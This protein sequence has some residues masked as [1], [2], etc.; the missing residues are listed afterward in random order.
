M[1][2]ASLVRQALVIWLLL[3]MSALA[4]E[5]S[6]PG[7]RTTTAEIRIEARPAAL[8]DGIRD[9]LA[10]KAPG[11]RPRTRHLRP[12]GSP[13]YTNRLILEDSPYL[14]Q[15]AHNP[16]DWYPWGPEAF[17]KARRER[18][19][20]FLSIGYST[21]HWCHVMEG[22]S[23]EDPMIA[24]LLNRHF[25]PIKVDRE[26]RPE[27]DETYM[28]AVMLI[29]G[30][31]G[32][33]LS[34][35][36]TP[37]GRPFH[38][39]TYYPPA[40]FL[41]LL[42]RITELWETQQ[43]ALMAR[44]ERIAES[45]DALARGRVR[46][47]R[48]GEETIR[49]AVAEALA[50]QDVLLGGFGD[51]PKFPNEPLL[52]LL[53]AAA[54]RHQDEAALA[55]LETTLDAMARGGIHD[56][57]GGGFHRYAID[58]EWQV[59][60]FEKM[61]YNQALLSRIYL[62]AWRLTGE[63]R[64]RRVVTRILDYVL[65]DM[66]SPEG[67]F[68]SATDADSEGREGAFFLWT[69]EQIHKVLDQKDAEL[70]IEVLGVSAGGNFEGGNILYLPAPL[71]AVAQTKGWSLARLAQ[72]LDAILER[73]DQARKARP[74]PLR[75]EKI[76]TAWNGMMIGALAQAGDLLDAPGYREAAKK[77]ARFLWDRQYKGG[78][79][80]WRVRY[81]GR[82]SIEA[83]L[84]DYAFFAEGLLHLYDATGD[85]RWLARARELADAMLTHLWD[86]R[87]GGF[88]M[89]RDEAALTA[90]GRAKDGGRD[91]A[92]PSG[93]SAALRVLQMLSVRT[94]RLDD[95][96]R[97]RATLSAF[98]DG[99]RR[100]PSAFGYL[101]TAADALL[102]GEL[103]ARRYAA[104]GGVR[105][106][107][108]VIDD[109]RIAVDLDIAP[110]W[111]LNSS[112]P[113]QKGL[114]PTRLTL[115]AG[116]RLERAEYPQAEIRRLGFQSEPL[117]LYRGKVRILVRAQ[118]VDRTARVLP[119]ELELQACSD[120]LCLPPETL[121]LRLVPHSTLFCVLSAARSGQ[122]QGARAQE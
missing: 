69:P 5:V 19:P 45:V 47:E 73:L 3:S 9:A 103:G 99:I 113:L 11:Y 66:T 12:D 68:Y 4:S 116:W 64:Y 37:E 65:R 93:N 89:R 42:N 77:A 91:A 78:G 15:H 63:A 17:S 54:E 31:G 40:D 118:R 56:Q 49:A 57:V 50:R 87:S 96:K 24:D 7:T 74:H 111:H 119:I 101:L 53:L 95:A 48:V 28:T 10:A 86:D 84:E 16:V 22:E 122:M 38:G 25:V 51:A 6:S 43:E 120:R 18:K 13:R 8:R 102:H 97:A 115:G 92:V 14:I 30:H 59:P 88:F 41:T 114:I 82:S 35:F 105:A 1:I 75:D 52:F 27:V 83:R 98:S 112:Q 71:E 76:L 110:G 21:C 44:S 85:D 106:R 79:G 100:H 90:M 72:R 20:I 61:L 34:T 62:G 60:H 108:R 46:A 109:E 67:A 104:S 117:S 33:P 36:L 55:A 23:F 70:A 26:R 39:G 107:A 80:L 81:A 29:A 121:T 94:D 2:E 32:W 58:P